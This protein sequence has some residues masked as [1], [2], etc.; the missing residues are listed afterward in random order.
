MAK[1]R[2]K[3]CSF[4][5]EAVPVLA[6]C[7]EYSA[8]LSSGYATYTKTVKTG[9]WPWVSGKSPETLLIWSLFARKRRVH[10]ALTGG[11]MLLEAPSLSLT[12]TR[13][14]AAYSL[15]SSTDENVMH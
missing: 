7:L 12:H 4:A 13:L 6:E 3:S 8:P 15:L 2:L 11:G 14:V 1:S 10:L 9:F 5:H